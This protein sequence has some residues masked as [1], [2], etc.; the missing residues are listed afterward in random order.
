MYKLYGILDYTYIYIWRVI[1]RNKLQKG[2]RRRR[3]LIINRILETWTNRNVH[4]LF[5]D[6][7]G[8]QGKNTRPYR[9]FN[10]NYY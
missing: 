6:V 4:Y 7:C 10:A 5:S 3:I 9:N 1:Y 2:R 8:N